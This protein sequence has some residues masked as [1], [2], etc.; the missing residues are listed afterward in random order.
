MRRTNQKG[1]DLI[2]GFEG[3]RLSPYRD[4]VGLLTVGY[5]HLVKPGE[6][7]GTLTEPEAETLLRADL[8]EAESA[9]ERLV[10]VPLTDN[11]HAA[12]VSF[13][14]NCGSGNLEKST[15]L[16][17]VNGEDFTGASFE[18]LKW[19]KAGGRVLAGL[20]RRRRAEMELFLSA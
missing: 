4:P 2:K 20:V 18:F 17:K 14:F 9:V 12:L 5:G 8:H 13:V 7:F 19:N 16:R 3:L 10:K 6:H 15:L 1:V 11:Q